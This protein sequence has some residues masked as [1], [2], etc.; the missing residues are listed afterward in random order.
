MALGR[1]MHRRLPERD[2]TVLD[3]HQAA[4]VAA[5]AEMIIPETDTPGAGA[6]RVHAFIDLLLAEWL[7][8]DARAHFLAGLA[9]VDARARAAF[10]GDFLAGTEAQR[11]AILTQLDAQAPAQRRPHQ[12]AP[13]PFFAQMKWLTLYGYYSS[14][15]GAKGELRYEAVPGSYDGCAALR[16]ARATPGDF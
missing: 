5:V 15:V 13:R 12:G 9:D 2:L 11:T 3:P 4:T 10:G 14:D 7:P 8:D 1:A 16:D 6:A